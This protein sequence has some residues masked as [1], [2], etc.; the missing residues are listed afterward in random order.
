MVSPSQP[1]VA[2]VGDDIVLPC[3]LEPAVDAT[4]LTVEWGRPDLNTRFV[5]VWRH[6]VELESKK[7]S[8]YVGRTSLSINKLKHGDVS[9]KLYKVKL[10][11]EGTYRCFIPTLNMESTVELVVGE[12]INCIGFLGQNIKVTNHIFER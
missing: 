1:I 5:H 12:W 4:D 10:S 3:H 6:G 7:H 2:T 11:D 9:L 8:S